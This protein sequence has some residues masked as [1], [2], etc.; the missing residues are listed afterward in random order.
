MQTP[1]ST[2]G[3]CPYCGAVIPERRLLIEYETADGTGCYAECE[4][5]EVVHPE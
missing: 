2:L 4:C 3:T 1:S 5:G